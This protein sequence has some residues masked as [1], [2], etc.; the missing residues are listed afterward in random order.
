MTDQNEQLWLVER[1]VDGRNVITLIYA[2][3]DGSRY[4]RRERAAAG[5]QTGSSVTAAIE[6]E[7]SNLRHVEDEETRARYATE[8]ERTANRYEPDDPL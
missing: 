4:H 2:T 7:E 6:V 5:L 3:P 1:D 8:V